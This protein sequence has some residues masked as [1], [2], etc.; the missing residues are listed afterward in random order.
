MATV[1]ITGCN[2]GIGLELCRQYMERGDKVL[3]VCRQPSDELTAT[4]ARV[5]PGVD[6]AD[7]IV[8]HDGLEVPIRTYRPTGDD[9]PRPTLVWLHGGGLVMGTHTDDAQCSRL[10]AELGGHPPPRSGGAP[11]RASSSWA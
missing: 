6:V 9:T 4:G 8:S 3:A 10:V 5:I 2:R 1:V 11:R 7:T